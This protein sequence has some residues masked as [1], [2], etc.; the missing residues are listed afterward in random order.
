MSATVTVLSLSASLYL[1]T[2]L[3]LSLLHSGRC[4]F[5]RAPEIHGDQMSTNSPYTHMHPRRKKK[6]EKG[7]RKPETIERNQPRPALSPMSL[8]Q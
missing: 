7:T 3:S 2:D 8:Q 6:S 1:A 4:S 5:S